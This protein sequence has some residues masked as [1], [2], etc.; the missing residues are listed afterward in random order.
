MAALDRN[1]PY[2]L[3]YGDGEGR[4]FQQDGVYFGADGSPWTAPGETPAPTKPAKKAA[5]NQV[6]A[7]MQEPT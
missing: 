3:V 7:Q 2:A 1:K 5:A 4:H 6:D